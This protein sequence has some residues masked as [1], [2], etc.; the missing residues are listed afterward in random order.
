MDHIDIQTTLQRLVLRAQIDNL[1]ETLTIYLSPA[2]RAHTDNLM[3]T[4][5][6]IKTRQTKPEISQANKYT[7]HRPHTYL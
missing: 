2:L 6:E 4:S 1:I 5:V 3:Q 7:V